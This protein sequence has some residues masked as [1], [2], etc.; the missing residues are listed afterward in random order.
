ME[1]SINR[2]VKTTQLASFSDDLECCNMTP[3]LVKQKLIKNS[4]NKKRSVDIDKSLLQTMLLNGDSKNCNCGVCKYFTRSKDIEN[5]CMVA[6][7]VYYTRIVEQKDY[8]LS[9]AKNK[10]DFLTNY[11]N[12]S[13]FCNVSHI[14]F[15]INYLYR[16]FYNLQ[17]PIITQLTERTKFPTSSKRKH[18]RHIVDFSFND[19]LKIATYNHKTIRVG[20]SIRLRPKQMTCKSGQLAHKETYKVKDISLF[21]MVEEDN[22]WLYHITDTYIMRIRPIAL[23]DLIPPTKDDIYMDSSIV[24]FKHLFDRSEIDL[25]NHENYLIIYNAEIIKQ[26]KSNTDIFNTLKRQKPYDHGNKR[27]DLFTAFNFVSMMEKRYVLTDKIH[28]HFNEISNFDKYLDQLNNQIKQNN[29][30]IETPINVSESDGDE[31]D[32]S[33]EEEDNKNETDCQDITTVSGEESNSDRK[34]SK[35]YVF[36]YNPTIDFTPST[37][38]L[39]ESC[40]GELLLRNDKAR[41]LFSLY[42]KYHI[43]KDVSKTYT[44]DRYINIILINTDTNRHSPQYHLYLNKKNII[45]SITYVENVL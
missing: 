1:A 33:D 15:K 18:T 34:V 3:E 43:L 31:D 44:N 21:E 19:F 27:Y 29:P 28:N 14:I 30:V 16:L 11:I 2:F 23:I 8:Y 24:A 35:Q 12:N 32:D 38:I 13:T 25:G 22:G 39:I 20:D 45:R 6:S 36:S 26:N 37:K 40:I 17:Y 5:I 42:N 9:Y 7:R 10:N 41:E 4:K